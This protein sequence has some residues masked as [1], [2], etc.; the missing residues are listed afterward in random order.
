MFKL[1]R[2]YDEKELNYISDILFVSLLKL[3][4]SLKDDK[5][6]DTACFVV[7]ILI[8]EKIKEF[9]K[10]SNVDYIVVNEILGSDN[11]T[12]L[13]GGWKNVFKWKNSN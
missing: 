2:R 10:D 6:N 11:I 4:N 3:I 9:L 8:A 12:A 1:K 13:G 7:L 5:F